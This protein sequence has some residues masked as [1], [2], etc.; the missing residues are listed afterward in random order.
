MA[1]A[2]QP[3]EAAGAGLL[4]WLRERGAPHLVVAGSVESEKTGRVATAFFPFEAPLEE[5]AAHATEVV[6]PAARAE[7][8]P[9]E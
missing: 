3:R 9:G 8:A 7:V 4:I 1:A 6:A 5:V 2:Q